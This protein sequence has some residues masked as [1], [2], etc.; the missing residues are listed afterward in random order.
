MNENGNQSGGIVTFLSDDQL[1]FADRFDTT[2]LSLSTVR[3]KDGRLEP[4]SQTWTWTVYETGSWGS[5]TWQDY[6]AIHAVPLPNQRFALLGADSSIQVFSTSPTIE[7][8]TA[9]GEFAQKL[10]IP[11]D[12]IATVD[13][14][15]WACGYGTKRFRVS[16]TGVVTLHGSPAYAG[17]E[18]FAC[19]VL[20]VAPDGQT[21]YATTAEGIVRWKA[22][23]EATPIAEV[24][25]PG[26]TGVG[27]TVNNE[28][29]AV[30]YVNRVAASGPVEVYR[31]ESK[32]LVARYIGSVPFG[33]TLTNDQ[34]VSGWG[35]L[36]TDGLSGEQLLRWVSTDGIGSRTD[37]TLTF[38]KTVNAEDVGS[39]MS[40][41]RF[42]SRNR[43]IVTQPW[44]RVFEFS[45]DGGA[46][47]E[48]VGDGQG[49]IRELASVD[50]N[51]L[52]AV[53]PYRAQT[54]SVED[55]RLSFQSGSF[56]PVASASHRIHVVLPSPG[57]EDA[58]FESRRRPWKQVAEKETI[59]LS[60]ATKT[61]VERLCELELDG[62]PATVLQRG[63]RL[64]QVASIG[65]REF[66]VRAYALDASVCNSA[67]V[68]TPAADGTVSVEVDAGMVDRDAFAVD[69][70]PETGHLVIAEARSTKDGEYGSSNGV[71]LGIAL[72]TGNTPKVLGQWTLPVLSSSYLPVVTGDRILVFQSG[73]VAVYRFGAT[74][75]EA[76]KPV[77]LGDFYVRDALA[78]TRGTPS[79]LYTSGHS[80]T[81][82]GYIEELLVFDLNTMA[83]RDR[84][85][86]P[87]QG[88][89]VAQVGAKL[90]VATNGSV[91]LVTPTCGSGTP[92]EP[93]PWP[94]PRLTTPPNEDLCLPLSGGC[95]DW[96]APAQPGDVNH[97]GCVNP[98]DATIVRNCIK[99]ATDRCTQSILADLNG[100]VRGCGVGRKKSRKRL[101]RKSN[102]SE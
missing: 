31:L 96:S 55:S 94:V 89:S 3:I 5:W 2:G 34:L 15:I 58:T 25:I 43:R 29:V 79:L 16:D 77:T 14:Q 87:T 40:S 28:Y 41:D 66:R 53:G 91:H 74:G 8:L 90:A 83:L 54:L 11:S 84:Y 21:V 32:E 36:S 78:V 6:P 7:P 64:Y 45:E 101:L 19:Y 61:G 63:S 23:D 24:V 52:V 76:E 47:R 33:I 60:R 68:W 80:E 82:A 57:S 81:A 46:L 95:I 48:L 69:V 86:L 22:S 49:S 93:K 100:D 4:I 30:Q 42:S 67:P 97:D 71:L 12:A 38:R 1:L 75:V 65:Q 51:T 26:V 39:S 20:A 50:A 10:G 35:Q 102:R 18:T 37:G 99:H 27:L 70:D 92:P 56:F 73:E 98:A 72:E 9:T 59:S 85:T 62:G 13:G 44:R 88:L 17:G